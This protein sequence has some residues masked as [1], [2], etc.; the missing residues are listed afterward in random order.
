MS[1]NWRVWLYLGWVGGGAWRVV[2]KI[3]LHL[4]HFHEE[5]QKLWVELG[6]SLLGESIS[7]GYHLSEQASER[8]S[9]VWGTR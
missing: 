8:V 6:E 9:K 4:P 5:M 7:S 3:P 1:H 2:L